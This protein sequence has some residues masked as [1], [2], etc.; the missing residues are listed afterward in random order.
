MD[1]D[2]QL[3]K[4]I[5][6]LKQCS[7]VSPCPMHSEY[8]LIKQRLKEIFESKTIQNLADELKKDSN[9]RK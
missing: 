9:K 7:E 5:L 6:G 8:K 2:G 4:C 1:D 3:E